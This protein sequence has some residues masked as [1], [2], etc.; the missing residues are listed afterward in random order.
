MIVRNHLGYGYETPILDTFTGVRAVRYELD[1]QDVT[2]LAHM[3]PEALQELFERMLAHF[4]MP[5]G[6]DDGQ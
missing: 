1:L 5:R 4:Y 2:D 6:A 3:A